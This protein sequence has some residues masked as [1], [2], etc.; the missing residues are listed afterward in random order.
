MVL[1][2]TIDVSQQRPLGH[3]GYL[4]SLCIG[5][6]YAIANQR[7]YGTTLALREL[8]E[9]LA[10]HRASAFYCGRMCEGRYIQ[11]L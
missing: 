8:R 10:C 6:V 2:Y 1:A 11:P 9:V 4:G 5:L 7:L 3:T